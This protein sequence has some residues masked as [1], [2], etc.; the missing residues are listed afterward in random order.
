MPEGSLLDEVSGEI[1]A[2]RSRP[3]GF[4]I[5]L[6]SAMLLVVFLTVTFGLMLNSVAQPWIFG[7]AAITYMMWARGR[8]IM[9]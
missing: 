7:I 3:D 5:F 8:G 2:A 1:E 9:E 4:M 6:R